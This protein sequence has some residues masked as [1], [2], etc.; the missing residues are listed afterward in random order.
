MAE[1]DMV[2][3]IRTTLDGHVHPLTF[4]GVEPGGAPNSYTITLRL[5]VKQLAHLSAG[6]RAML[7]PQCK[8]P[9]V[10][11]AIWDEANKRI[12]LLIRTVRFA[13]SPSNRARALEIAN[14][15][16]NN[17]GYI[18]RLSIMDRGTHMDAGLSVAQQVPL[19]EHLEI[20]AQI[21]LG[22]VLQ[23][24]M[25]AGNAATMLIANLERDASAP[26]H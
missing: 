19:P 5:D 20:S 14:E 1:F 15:H 21:L 4:V 2:G 16:N 7:E 22:T 9:L 23:L 25:E 13:G 17:V 26:A 11:V 6:L 24:A 3:F 12:T 10:I 18:S 8:E